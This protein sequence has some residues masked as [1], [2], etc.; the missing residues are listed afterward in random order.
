MPRRASCCR[1]CWPTTT[2]G[3]SSW[4]AASR[5]SSG[6]TTSS[7]SSRTTGWPRSAGPIRPSSASPASWA[8]RCIATND[9]HYTHRDDAVAHDAL[10]CVQTGALIDDPKRFK[11]EGEEHYLKSAAEMRT[12]F[13]E[14][15]EAC[16]NTLLIAERANV[17]IEFGV[18]A[19]PEFPVPD[20]VHRGQ[21]RGAGRRLSPSSVL[22]RGA[23]ALRR[24]VAAR[25]RG[26]ARLRARR[27]H[28]HGVLGLL[29]GRVGPHPPRPDERHPGRSRTGIGGRVLRGVL[30]RDRRPRPHPLRPAVRALP[31]SRAQADARHRHGLR[32]ALPGA[33]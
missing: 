15:P 19:L 11:F 20:G 2:S 8:R 13:S 33:R 28:Q 4:P 24:P 9:S 7:W 32:R 3:R 14:V 5:T 22:R 30:P 10:L 21:L 18:N 29:P 27:H 25:C 1:R 23:Q 12:L 16:D 6:A 17:E 31:E 26:T